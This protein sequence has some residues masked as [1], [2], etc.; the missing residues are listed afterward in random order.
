MKQKEE[1]SLI[2]TDW[3]YQER[4]ETVVNLVNRLTHE[5][6]IERLGPPAVAFHLRD[7][8]RTFHQ[9]AQ[10]VSLPRGNLR[11][12]YKKAVVGTDEEWDDFCERLPAKLWR[13]WTDID[14][15]PVAWRK[16]RISFELDVDDDGIKAE[17]Y[18]LLQILVETGADI[19]RLRECRVC[20]KLFWASRLD[21]KGGPF[22]CSPKCNNAL[23]QREHKAKVRLAERD[24]RQ[25]KKR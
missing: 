4:L 13:G 23:Y 25:R 19:R 10:I 6:P 1:V 11:E 20:L 5:T 21:K 17:A 12:E 18:H 7:F 15:S 24:A 3:S 2:F 14:P 8:C 22:G 16:P 9:I